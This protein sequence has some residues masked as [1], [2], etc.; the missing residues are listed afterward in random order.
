MDAPANRLNLAHEAPFHL[1]DLRVEPALRL[2]RNGEASE[3]IEPRVMKLLVALHSAGGHILSRYDLIEQCWNGQVVGE[4]A[5]QRAVSQA[6]KIAAGIGK[7]FVRI[8]SIRGVGYRLIP[9]PKSEAEAVS[10]DDPDGVGAPDWSHGDR[11]LLQTGPRTGRTFTGNSVILVVSLAALVLAAVALLLSNFTDGERQSVLAIVVSDSQSD[12]KGSAEW[13]QRLSGDLARLGRTQTG[14]SRLV[15]VRPGSASI[16]EQNAYRIR[17]ARNATGG[18][19]TADAEILAPGDQSILWSGNFAGTDDVA[20]REQLAVKVAYLLRCLVSAID[21]GLNQSAAGIYVRACEIAHDEPGLARVALLRQVMRHSPE[22][23]AGWAELSLAEAEQAILRS[24][25]SDFSDDT[26][27]LAR[28]A[29]RYLKAARR[30]HPGAPATFIAE[31]SLHSLVKPTG[32]DSRLELYTKAISQNPD[33][34]SLYAARATAFFDLGRLHDATLDARRAVRL[35]PLSPN[36][37]ATLSELLL[38]QGLVKAATTVLAEARR[39]WP[40]SGT[41]HDAH[42]RYLLR[43]GDPSEALRAM[44]EEGFSSPT[45]TV[46]EAYLTARQSRD[47][48]DIENAVRLS[49]KM[50]ERQSWWA[51]QHVQLLGHFNRGDEALDFVLRDRAAMS[52]LFSDPTVLYRDYTASLRQHPRVLRIAADTGVLRAWQRSGRWPDFCSTPSLRYD[53]RKVAAALDS[54]D[55]IPSKAVKAERAEGTRTGAA[56]P[57]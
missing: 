47:P 2:V 1:G 51:I 42:R 49:R 6:R 14:S 5:I 43:Y 9:E 16:A 19:K 52:D 41:V 30:L 53:C 4:N 27:E 24:S 17:V 25:N 45:R 57:G 54:P 39:L 3:I 26:A 37:R 8:E 23:G 13:T 29:Q 40:E 44:E 20:L 10:A 46:W 35:D 56:E 50:Y 28:S 22:F 12:T 21:G 36:Y 48:E 32:W 11:P 7:G 55:P 18:I 31:G 33:A 15:E 34:A 38:Y